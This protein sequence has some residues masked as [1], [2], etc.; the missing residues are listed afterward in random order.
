M[1]FIHSAY[2]S[3]VLISARA[4]ACAENVESE[5]QNALQAALPFPV[6]PASKNTFAC[7]FIVPV[8]YPHKKLVIANI[9]C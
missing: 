9:Q 4:P 6:S 7:C 3:T 5:W 1:P 2:D 8:F